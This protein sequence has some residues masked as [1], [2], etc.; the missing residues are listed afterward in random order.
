MFAVIT[1]D[2]IGVSPRGTIH[3]RVWVLALYFGAIVG[4][5]YLG[6]NHLVANLMPSPYRTEFMALVLLRVS[7]WIGLAGGA[8]WWYAASLDD[9]KR[10]ALALRVLSGK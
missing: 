7:V 9:L 5:N 4:L 10:E 8:L 1:G 3:P 2:T 6:I